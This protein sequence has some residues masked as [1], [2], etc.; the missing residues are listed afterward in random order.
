M[1]LLKKLDIVLILGLGMIMGL[2]AGVQSALAHQVHVFAYVQGGKVYTES[3]FQDGRKV[4]KGKIRVYDEEGRLVQKG[5]TDSRGEF[6]FEIPRARELLIKLDASMGHAASFRL[7]LAEDKTERKKS[8][9]K[10][11][12]SEKQE[13]TAAE[14]KKST[15]GGVLEKVSASKNQPEASAKR[16]GSLGEKPGGSE[17]AIEQVRMVVDQELSKH[18]KPLSRD[19]AMLKAEK[20]KPSI[21]EIVGGIGYIIGI[22][23]LVL[24]FKSR[25]S[26]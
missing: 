21:T 6:S 11:M 5:I 9:V 1:L 19:I 7:K 18:L 26:V 25:R 10:N 20:N 3:Y 13:K 23:G 16:Y 12:V 17:A 24:Y 14:K 4:A 22:M 2:G 15:A 8:S